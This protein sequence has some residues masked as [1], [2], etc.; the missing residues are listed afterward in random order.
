M[1]LDTLTELPPPADLAA[2]ARGLE[3]W[4]SQGIAN[5]EASVRAFAVH[6]AENRN[7]RRLLEGVFGNSPYLGDALARDPAFVEQIFA[8][9]FDATQSALL[10]RLN[11][12]YG[13]ETDT[14][15]LMT[16]LRVAKRR[17]ALLIALADITG[18][19]TLEPVTAALSDIAETA[20]H[21]TCR[22]LLRKAATQGMIELPDH[23][24]PEA[25]SGLIVLGMGKLG[26]CELNYSS[27]I[28]LIVFYDADRV[29]ARRPETL[30]RD[31]IRLTRELVRIMDERTRDGYVFRTDLRLRPDPA[32]TPLAVSVAAAETYYP[33]VGQNW[34]RAALIK[35]RQVAGDTEAGAGLLR[36]LSRF[37]WRRNLD[38][39]A[40]QDIHS[41][42]RQIN[43]SKG[44]H[45]I[46]VLGHD[47]KVGRGGI[48]EIEFFAQTQQLIFGGRDDRLRKLGTCA[49]IESLVATGRVDRAAADE[50]IA[51]YR[52]L[53]RAEHRIQMVDDRQTHALPKTDEGVAAIAAFLGY[54]DVAGFRADLLGHLAR[55]EES[56]ARLFEEAP[57]LSS[58]GNLVFTGTDD[59]PGTVETLTTLGFAHPS[60]VITTVAGWHRGRTHTMRSARARELL[61]E[62]VPALLEAFGRTPAPDA[63]LAG[64]DAFLSHLPTGVQLFSLFYSNPWL[65]ELVALILGTAPRLAETLGRNPGLLEGVLSTGSLETLPEGAELAED[66]LRFL[67]GTDDFEEVMFRAR[68]W[69]AE[70]KFRAGVHILR[71]VTDGD[72]AGPFLSDLADVVLLDVCRRVSEEFRRR[73]GTFPGTDVAIIA[74]GKLGSRQMS[75]ESDLDLIIVYHVPTGIAESDGAK[76]LSPAEYYTRW[77]KRLINAV[78][79]QSADGRLYEIDMRL[80]PSGNS[81]P[82]AVSLQAFDRYQ[83]EQAWTWEHMALTRARIIGGRHPLRTGLAGT[84]HDVLTRDRDPAKL[85][86]DVAEMRRRVDHE[87]GTDNP[88]NVKYFRGGFLDINFIV[89]YLILRHAHRHPGIIAAN[90]VTALENLAAAGVL[91]PRIAAELIPIHRLWRRVQGYLRL[92]SAQVLKP[93]AM[94]EALRATLGPVVFP[95]RE[96]PIPFADS[97]AEMRRRAACAFGHYQRLI[98]QPAAALVRET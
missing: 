73:H 81:G 20:L 7:G 49:A 64:F 43:A 39:A 93:A 28:D 21:L 66:Y 29:R 22:H 88:W 70:Q 33:S 4:R 18:T 67:D 74:M 95:G 56:Y 3:R 65:L 8:N 82:V 55:V 94:P 78:T 83:H 80:R 72:R 25:G 31:M 24:H 86:L 53:R 48:R 51:A 36:F 58:I 35:A 14:A 89:Q 6:L 26:A 69:T 97:E 47:L 52:F 63:A 68:R 84:F 1:L 23:D 44:H 45:I 50:L 15:R 92:I 41:I 16:G 30:A 62:L 37:I 71:S 90:T 10:T 61:T 59:D 2:A 38:F 19:W 54:G 9:G 40:I 11:Q 13:Q 27:D 5:G 42:K 85:L 98:E 91:D 75:I 76:P 87:F 60:S 32:S 34:E 12:D 96:G 57:P 17:A 46:A 77:T 79:A